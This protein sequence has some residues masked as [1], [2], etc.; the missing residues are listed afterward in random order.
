MIQV[1]MCW[2]SPCQV[3]KQHFST[4]W[5]RNKNLPIIPI[6]FKQQTVQALIDTGS[7]VPL[8]AEDVI[9]DFEES[10][11]FTQNELEAYSCNGSKLD[12]PG[13]ITG[14]LLLHQHDAPIRAQFYILKQ[15]TQECI[16]PHTWLEKLKAVLDYNTNTLTYQIP[17]DPSILTAT[18]ELEQIP[19]TKEEEPTTEVLSL[20][21]K[22]PI[23]I[24]ANTQ[25]IITLPANPS[26]PNCVQVSTCHGFVRGNRTGS[27]QILTLVNHTQQPITLDRNTQIQS[28]K[29]PQLRTVL[30][31]I[32]FFWLVR[33]TRCIQY[34]I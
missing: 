17:T 23:Y 11:M 13:I 25:K 5:L 22:N 32:H 1:C 12:I 20:N 31:K 4:K 14:D 29:R 28:I 30:F 7:M 34:T 6:N 24:P 26:W 3:Q 2:Q 16:L 10:T 19:I 9:P 21:T 33:S 15:S 27:K 18:G 8:I